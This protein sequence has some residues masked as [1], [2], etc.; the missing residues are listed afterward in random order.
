MDFQEGWHQGLSPHDPMLEKRRPFQRPPPSRGEEVTALSPELLLVFRHRRTAPRGFCLP[1][2]DVTDRF[3][4]R[5]LGP[6]ADCAV[7]GTARSIAA[8]WDLHV[9]AEFADF[10][11]SLVIVFARLRAPRPLLDEPRRRGTGR[12]AGICEFQELRSAGYPT[13]LETRTVPADPVLLLRLVSPPLNRSIHR[14]GAGRDQKKGT[15]GADA[16]DPRTHRGR[17]RLLGHRA[18]QGGDAPRPPRHQQSREGES[19]FWGAAGRGIGLRRV[20][21][22]A[23]AEGGLRG[24]LGFF[25]P[26][27]LRPCLKGGASR[28]K[29][30]DDMTVSSGSSRQ[31][32]DKVLNIP[33]AE[34]VDSKTSA[35][36]LFACGVDAT[37]DT[38]L[39]L[40]FIFT[41]CVKALTIPLLEPKA[42]PYPYNT[43]KKKRADWANPKV[44]ALFWTL[45]VTDSKTFESPKTT[46]AKAPSS[47]HCT[48]FRRTLRLGR[49]V[50]TS[51][52]APLLLVPVPPPADALIAAFCGGS[53]PSRSPASHVLRCVIPD[54]CMRAFFLSFVHYTPWRSDP[55]V[56]RL[57]K[58]VMVFDTYVDVLSQNFN[59]LLREKCFSDVNTVD[60]I[61]EICQCFKLTDATL[62]RVMDA[63]VV[64]MEKGLDPETASTAAMKML[65]SYVRAVPNGTEQGD[66]LA[67]DLGGTNFRVL[68]IRLVDGE[69]KMEGKIFRV[70]DRLMKGTGEQLFDHI[71]QCLADF[72]KDHHVMD[73]GRLPLGFTFS[74][75]CKQEGLTC[76]K[77]VS[78]TKGFNASGVEGEDVVQLLHDACARRNDIDIDVVAVLNDT[79]G[80]LM[81]CAYLE[82]SCQIGVIVGTGFNACY[83][84]KME[85]IKKMAGEIDHTKDGLPD[86]MIVNTEWGGFGDDGE[87]EFIR[88]KFDQAVDATT[89]NPGKHL[90]EKMISGMYL[91]EVVRVVLEHLARENLIFNGDFDAISVPHSFP[92]KYVS[93]IERDLIEDDEK[94]FAKTMTI[95]EEIGIESVTPADCA[96]VAYV[97]SVVSTRAAHIAAAGIAVLLNRMQKPFVTV[98]VDGSVYRFHPTFSK[99]LDEKID[100][101]IEGDI[102]YQLMLSEDGSGRGAALVAAVATRMAHEQQAALAT[103]TGSEAIVVSNAEFTLATVLR[104]V[105]TVLGQHEKY[106]CD[107]DADWSSGTRRL[108][109]SRDE[110]QRPLMP[111][112][113]LTNAAIGTAVVLVVTSIAGY[114]YLKKFGCCKNKKTKKGPIT[115]VDPRVKYPLKLIKKTIVSHDTRKFRFALPSDRHVLGLPTG[116]HICLSAKVDGKLVVRLYTPISSDDDQGYVELMIKVYFKGV[117]PKFPEGG[118]MSQHLDSLSIGDTV[119]FRGPSGLITYE[120][121]G[122]FDVRSDKKS[123]AAPRQFKRVGMIAGGTGI[124]P[125][126]QVIHAILKDPSDRTE[127]SLLFANQTEKDI[128]CREELE[129]LQKEHGDRFHL[130]YTVDRAEGAWKYSVGYVDQDMIEKHLPSPDPETAILMCGPPGMIKFA[131]VPNL[132]KIGHPAHSTFTF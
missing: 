93:E 84:E 18:D 65:P 114:V 121:H 82:N 128:L 126:L 123:A 55:P 40:Q 108:K 90:Y 97:C 91:G 52:H 13:A 20:L 117:H 104:L 74:F 24:L 75:P 67:L 129:A 3:V 49:P 39:C 38:V 116:Q 45:E 53:A 64:S 107:G 113:G 102:E 7:R 23:S 111:A 60:K 22:G 48:L 27:G 98:G 11:P 6:S 56:E 41:F 21:D 81:A 92:T 31:I 32:L 127:L 10:V 44:Y 1:R 130:W 94:N 33:H 85:R 73:R 95:L 122:R 61:H 63:M 66:F 46:L 80:T 100:D 8:S 26:Q 115:L 25:G 86:E 101:L 50:P 76:A 99:L 9:P 43:N 34:A 124:T 57:P 119:N 2:G 79:T 14:K 47:P 30:T 109:D 118:K 62:K 37:F 112:S 42:H 72:M 106:F 29:V 36:L 71:A 131:C 88:T 54:L 83:M 12:R 69:S 4:L 89:I 35:S 70:P 120:G 87:I 110:Y 15:P 16:A 19:G 5:S 125:M 28:A 68:L 51:Y 105:L 77:L 103:Q 17:R 96:N 59:S 78:W 58:R 132:E